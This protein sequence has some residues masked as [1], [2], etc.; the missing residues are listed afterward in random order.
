MQQKS[1]N[2]Y[3]RERAELAGVDLS[4]HDLAVVRER[5]EISPS[6]HLDD[7]IMGLRNL[8]GTGSV[9]VITQLLA[10]TE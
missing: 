9:T 3:I 6:C 2:G 7:L 1:L 10:S 5:W 4:D 8:A